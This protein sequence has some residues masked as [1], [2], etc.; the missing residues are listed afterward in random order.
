MPM[1]AL[2]LIIELLLLSLHVLLLLLLR[3][4]L[5]AVGSGGAEY[6]CQG[7]EVKRRQRSED[8]ISSYGLDNPRIVA[9]FTDLAIS[10][11]IF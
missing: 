3:V 4:K 7:F 9:L 1:A 5:E 2:L 10:F 6:W 11:C 8:T